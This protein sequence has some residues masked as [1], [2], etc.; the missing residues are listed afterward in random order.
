MVQ[1]L[2]Q[3]SRYVL[4]P[5]RLD[6]LLQLSYREL[7]VAVR[8]ERLE[9]LGELRDLLLGQLAGNDAGRCPLEL[10]HVSKSAKPVNENV[11]QLHVLSIRCL[12]R[13]PDVHQRLLRRVPLAGL[14]LQQAPDQILGV[15]GHLLPVGGMEGEFRFRDFALELGVGVPE[16]RGV[17][18]EHDEHE[19]AAAPQV[20]QVG[21][22]PRQRLRRDVVADGG[23]CRDPLAGLEP[24]RAVEV[25]DLQEVVLD[26]VP[27]HEQEVLRLQIAVA[28]VIFVHVENCLQDLLHKVRGHCL[29]EAATINDAI[30]ELAAS[31]ELHHEVNVSVILVRLMQLYYVRMVHLRHDFDLLFETVDV[32]HLRLAYVLDSIHIAGLLVLGLPH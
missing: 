17:P 28:D 19:D 29:R 16:E 2:L 32:F 8:V 1:E 3:V 25:G 6:A 15:L 21:G 20:A 30:K 12:V 5:G 9:R 18:A 26:L 24:T 27:G 14:L 31:T 4:Q 7:S 11:I 10:G 13:D 22:P 23:L